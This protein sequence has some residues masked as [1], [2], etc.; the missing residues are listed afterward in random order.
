MKHLFLSL[1]RFRGR[2]DRRLA[3][4]W[5]DLLS[6]EL[7]PET[8]RRLR[9]FLARY[10]GR[11][12]RDTLWLGQHLL[13]EPATPIGMSVRE[14]LSQHGWITGATG[15]GKTRFA[16][17]A[18]IQLMRR[19]RVPKIILDFKGELSR[20]AQEN[21]L[22]GLL[23]EPGVAEQLA[24]LRI[25]RPYGSPYI[26]LLRLTEPEPGIAPEVQALNLAMSLVEA[27]G[28]DLGIR[29]E[30]LFLK[31][32]ALAIELREPLTTIHRWLE[33]P[34][35]LARDALR[36]QDPGLRGYVRESFERETGSTREA[37]LARLDGFFLLTETRLALSAP[38]CLS[39]GECLESGVTI[40]NLG[41]PPAGA[42]RVSKFWA[43]VLVG[44]LSR[45]ILSRPVTEATPPVMVILEEFQEALSGSQIEQFKRLL[46]LARY[47]RVALWFVNQQVS[48]LAAI[49]PALPKILRTNIGIEV[50]F[51]CNAEDARLLAPVLGGGAPRRGD[52]R[53]D[54]IRELITLRDREF[55]FWAKREAYGPQKLRSLDLDMDAFREAA[56]TV[57]PRIRQA[58]EQGSVALPRRDLEALVAPAR[59]NRA[60]APAT[61]EPPPPAPPRGR[62]GRFPGLG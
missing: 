59:G 43:A 49:D 48:Q 18:L 36:S 50:I 22:P 11:R 32:C 16:Q 37:L 12:N 57:D 2:T 42:E 10:S 31:L 8:A 35:S 19:P 45:A 17:G 26:P 25:I 3:R 44:R 29:M 6:H 41:E 21:L 33:N 27:L 58:M 54:P 30:R 9:A 52:H 56:R 62:R 51:R 46:A 28:Q 39:F 1:R 55:L 4:E 14:V 38:R 60:A 5:Q 24:Q 23:N 13:T 34:V 53:P 40:I 20:D 15:S 47:K 7:D 61:P